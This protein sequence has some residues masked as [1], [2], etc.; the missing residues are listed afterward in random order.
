M[1][2]KNNCCAKCKVTPGG[3]G[4]GLPIYGSVRCECHTTSVASAR[5]ALLEELI[6]GVEKLSNIIE[7]QKGVTTADLLKRSFVLALLEQKKCQHTLSYGTCTKCG[8]DM[9]VGGG[10]GGQKKYGNS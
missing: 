6:E 8:V 4:G 9:S 5:T 3:S 10:G 7:F 2:E 1:K